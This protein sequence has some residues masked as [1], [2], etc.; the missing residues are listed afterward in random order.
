[1][2]FVTWFVRK[3]LVKFGVVEPPVLTIPE[4]ALHNVPTSHPGDQQ[5]V[6]LRLF[7]LF[8]LEQIENTSEALEQGRGVLDR[9]AFTRDMK[10]L[11]GVVVLLNEEDINFLRN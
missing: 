4:L 8:L 3:I 2:K 10:T 5:A 9:P 1:M 11:E 7:A 6:P